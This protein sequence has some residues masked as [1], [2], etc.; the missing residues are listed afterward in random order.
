MASLKDSIK[1]I[2]TY[3]RGIDYYNDAIMVKCEL[4]KKISVI[5]DIEKGIK[6]TH[7]ENGLTYY[8][9]N[10]NDV[11]IE[12]IFTLIET[13]IQVYEEARA[14]AILFREK[15]E[16][17][18]KLFAETDLDKLKTLYFNFSEPINMTKKKK[19]QTKKTNQP[20]VEETE[21][22]TETEKTE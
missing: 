12:D 10:K 19:R 13:T 18:K 2:E 3:F 9:G 7:D 22:I 17:L 14:K 15:C 16:E 1:K 8:Y 4:P 11:E 20:K 21:N 6:V 5:E